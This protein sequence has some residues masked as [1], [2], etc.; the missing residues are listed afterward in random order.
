MAR[1]VERPWPVMRPP[2]LSQC[3]KRAITMVLVGMAS[4]GALLAV[5]ES[6]ATELDGA[7]G[8]F[9]LPEPAGWMKFL[10]VVLVMVFIAR[11]NI[12]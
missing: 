4:A 9:A 6:W 2:Y 8:S 12:T 11:R 10:A 3:M 1:P 5:K 7:L